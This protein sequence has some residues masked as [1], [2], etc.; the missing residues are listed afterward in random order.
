L[1][2]PWLR[3]FCFTVKQVCQFTENEI[4]PAYTATKKMLKYLF[5]IL[6]FALMLAGYF[7]LNV[8]SETPYDQMLERVWRGGTMVCIGGLGS[9]FCVSR[10]S[11]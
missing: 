5:F 3:G 10:F 8:P 2:Y 4:L 9:I 1:F 11:R 7:S 6:F